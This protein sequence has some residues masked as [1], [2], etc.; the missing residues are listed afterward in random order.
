MPRHWGPQLLIS[1]IASR[2]RTTDWGES[3][4]TIRVNLP[5]RFAS[6]TSRTRLRDN[7]RVADHARVGGFA[8]AVACLTVQRWIGSKSRTVGI[9]D[10]CRRLFWMPRDTA[11]GEIARALS[12]RVELS[13]QFV[14][15]SRFIE[16]GWRIT[17]VWSTT[18]PQS[19][20]PLCTGGI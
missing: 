7:F 14:G 9:S 12:R 10:L 8:L 19:P 3:T 18:H 13:S 11:F 5:R 4:C 15:G 6:I 16:R 20:G 1:S 17:S 2:N